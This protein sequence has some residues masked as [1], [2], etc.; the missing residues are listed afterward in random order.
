MRLCV[1]AA[2]LSLRR[3]VVLLAA[4]LPL[5]LVT[6]PS[7]ATGATLPAAPTVTVE[8]AGQKVRMPDE[9]RSSRYRF[10]VKGHDGGPSGVQLLKV[11]KG[12]TRTEFLR[13]VELVDRGSDRA[14]NRLERNL[15]FFGGVFVDPGER[16]EFWETLYAG[17][18]WVISDRADLRQISDV[19]V[20]TVSGPV[21]ATAWPGSTGTLTM[22]EKGVKAPSELPRRG[23]LLVRNAGNDA[24]IFLVL[25]LVP[26][27][28]VEDLRSWDPEVDEE[29]P[30]EDIAVPVAMLSPDVSMLWGYSMRPGTYVVMNIGSMWFDEPDSPFELVKEIRIR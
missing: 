21:R 2:H 11:A 10:V 27:K 3:G 15:R 28:T 17:T 20:V 26:G 8:L 25:R 19:K 23:R 24:D 4:T 9:L 1:R 29:V 7:P 22:S 6:P 30:I 12:Y 13:D 5:A 14:E 16:G 18:Y